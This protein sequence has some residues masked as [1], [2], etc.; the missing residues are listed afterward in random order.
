M[1]ASLFSAR[2]KLRENWALYPAYNSQASNEFLDDKFGYTLLSHTDLSR[3]SGDSGGVN[4]ENFNWQNFDLIV[5][6]ESHNFRN[7]TKPREDKDGNFRHSRYSRLLEEVI[8]EG[9]KT[10]VLMLFR[11]TSKY[12]THRPSQSDISHDRKTRGCL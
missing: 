4:L 3:Y 1:N 2:K 12:F 10:K 6:D 11:D 9:T 5:I 8:K 7:D